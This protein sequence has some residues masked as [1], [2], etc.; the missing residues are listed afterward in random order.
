[1]SNEEL[2]DRLSLL[3][4]VM[5]LEQEYE[6]IESSES[7]PTNEA[8]EERIALLQRVTELEAELERE[9]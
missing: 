8:L 4:K 2:E 6:K 7:S 1:M 5:E 9:N 3:E